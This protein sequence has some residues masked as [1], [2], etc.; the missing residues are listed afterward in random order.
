M[1]QTLHC[2]HKLYTNTLLT[3]KFELTSPIILLTVVLL[4]LTKA[5]DKVLR[6]V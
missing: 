2:L 6:R 4:Q 1:H 3:Q 5:K